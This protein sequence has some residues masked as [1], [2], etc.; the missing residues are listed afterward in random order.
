MLENGNFS[1]LLDTIRDVLG[2]D[3]L[4]IEWETVRYF[5]DRIGYST[6][7]FF[8]RIGSDR[9]KSVKIRTEPKS[10]NWFLLKKKH[11][12]TLE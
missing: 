12:K 1:L 9:T 5:S 10:D 2:S 7:V 11:V 6:D 8:Y 3:R 4:R